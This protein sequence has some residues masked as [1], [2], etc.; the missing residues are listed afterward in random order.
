GMIAHPPTL[1]LG[2]A[3]YTI[4]FALMIGALAARRRDNQWIASTRRWTVVSCLSLS[5]GILLGAQWAYVELG[6]GGY[7]AWDPVENASLLPWLTGTALLHS[8]MVQQHRGMFK[9]WNASLIAGTFILCIFGTYLTR[10]GVIDSVHSF[11]KS[12][13]GTFFFWF[14]AIS[15]LFSIVFLVIRR[16]VLAAEQEMPGL[17]GKEGFF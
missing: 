7:W 5:I 13:I 12:L 9:K 6:W 1:F 8:I 16:K 3:G 15:I 10:S 17:I 4:P 11:G 2:Y 14:L